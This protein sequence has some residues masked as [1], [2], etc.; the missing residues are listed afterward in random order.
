MTLNLHPP[1]GRLCGQHGGPRPRPVVDALGQV[2]I[3]VLMQVGRQRP[4]AVLPD[5]DSERV[6]DGIQSPRSWV[7]LPTGVLLAV[8]SIH[9]PA[10]LLKRPR[11]LNNVPPAAANELRPDY[12]LDA[13]QLQEDALKELIGF[14]DFLHGRLHFDDFDRLT[15]VAGWFR[16]FRLAILA[17]QSKEFSKSRIAFAVIAISA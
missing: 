1:A 5:R 12:I 2:E 7:L 13:A 6:E 9:I 3:S 8:R 10:G 4:P 16:D 17:S 11:I 15:S 14:E